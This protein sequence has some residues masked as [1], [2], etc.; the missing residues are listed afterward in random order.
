M[1]IY[2]YNQ[3]SASAKVLAKA[4][5]VKRIK[6]EGGKY[7]A[8]HWHT[9]LN[10]GSSRTPYDLD[11]ATIINNSYAVASA[12]N[13]L[14]AFI[15]MEG[16]V[17]IPE[18]TTSHGQAVRWLAEGFT[19]VCRT[20][21]NGHSGKGIILASEEQHIVEAPLYV[22]YI[23]KNEEYR[24]HVHNGEVFFVQKKMR[25]LG[26]PD[27]DVNWKVRN[28]QNGFIYANRGV[29]IAQEACNNAIAAITSLGLDFGA[30]DI[31]YNEKEDKF[32]VLEVNT[33]PGISGTTL[34]KYVEQ[35]KIYL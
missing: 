25:K 28:H 11:D 22:K 2:S 27:D 35:L 26:V 12:S 9:I 13:K 34:E 32:Y 10:W 29:A 31:I 20:I 8:K 7:K 1:K 30:V 33:A 4:L 21:L 5:G 19:I 14:S 3:A 16:R 15:A 18:W 6:H 23:P 17:S 24:I